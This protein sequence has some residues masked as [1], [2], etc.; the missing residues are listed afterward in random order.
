MAR[1]SEPYKG[2]TFVVG[3]RPAGVHGLFDMAGNAWEYVADWYAPDYAT[4]GAACA[5]IDPKGP[6][7]GADACPGF[8]E[9]IVKGGSCVAV[10]S[11]RKGASFDFQCLLKRRPR[12]PFVAEVT[13]TTALGIG[14]S[15]GR[16]TIAV[17]KQRPRLRR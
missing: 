13:Y 15:A 12:R 4:C 2:R 3:S 5:G 8:T 1:S 10:M 14:R 11:K 17:P 7:G 16:V 9:K 6:C